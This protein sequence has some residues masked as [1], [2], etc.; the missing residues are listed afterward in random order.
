MDV[1]FVAVLVFSLA[2][3]LWKCGSAFL[4]ETSPRSSRA[5]SA[6]SF[7]LLASLFAAACI[8]SRPSDRVSWI[9]VAA[10]SVFA[11]D[12]PRTHSLAAAFLS[13]AALSE[14]VHAPSK[15]KSQT[16]SAS[17]ILCLCGA[18]I[19]ALGSLPLFLRTPPARPDPTRPP[20]DFRVPAQFTISTRAPFQL[21]SD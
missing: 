11:L 14:I 7:L 15:H 17:D 12:F 10:T 9:F 13:A 16:A 1:F 4:L 8:L 3:A 20:P 2:V 21:K 6:L 19:D 5:I 18:L